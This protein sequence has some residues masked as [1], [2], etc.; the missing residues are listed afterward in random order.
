MTPEQEKAAL[1]ARGIATP[2]Q[3]HE[4]LKRRVA[5]LEKKPPAVDPLV[6]A[7]ATRVQVLE[8]RL[9]RLEAWVQ[10]HNRLGELAAILRERNR[11]G[12]DREQ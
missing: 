11:D 7:L 12:A 6:Y 2:E 3:R 1:N 10:R 9:Q 4:L 5:A 8:R